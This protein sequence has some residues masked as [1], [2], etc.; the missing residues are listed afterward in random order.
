VDWREASVRLDIVRRGDKT[1]AVYTHPPQIYRADAG[2]CPH[3]LRA[4]GLWLGLLAVVAAVVL[5]LVVGRP[6][7]ALKL[8]NS[9][10]ASHLR[11]PVQGVQAKALTDS[12]GARRSDGRSHRGI[13]IFAPRGTPVVANTRGLVIDV[14]RNRLGGNF[15]RILGPGRHI[16]YFAHLD[17]FGRFRRGD[18]VDAGDVLGYVGT[19]GNARGTPPHLH[20]GIYALPGLAINPYPILRARPAS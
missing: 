1:G 14:G 2:V 9:P 19:T 11:V 18:V 5:A 12:W 8:M 3:R 17:A 15:I 16:H 13:D 7:V 6:I 20:Y 4:A 10:A